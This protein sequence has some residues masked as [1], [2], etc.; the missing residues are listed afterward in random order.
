MGVRVRV[1]ALRNYVVKSPPIIYG[2]P[3][4]REGPRGKGLVSAELEWRCLLLASGPR[5]VS[6]PPGCMSGFV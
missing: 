6:H 5:R 2:K 1:R 4:P 3:K